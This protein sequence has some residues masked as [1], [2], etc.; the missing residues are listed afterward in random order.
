MNAIKKFEDRA[1]AVNSLVCVGL[2]TDFERI[3]SEFR[4]HDAPQFAFNQWIIDQTH[5]YISAYK[6]NIAFYEARGDQGLRELK[7]TIDYLR[8]QH[9]DIFTI[10][11]A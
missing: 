3:P 6:P 7:Q 8:E 5:P 11:D 9:P 4:H 10:C 2:D 1:K